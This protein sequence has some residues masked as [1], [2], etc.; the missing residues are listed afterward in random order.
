MFDDVKDME[1]RY[2]LSD[3]WAINCDRGYA[4]LDPII[5]GSLI[6]GK[7]T[8]AEG[9]QHLALSVWLL[10]HKNFMQPSLP[11]TTGPLWLQ[12]CQVPTLQQQSPTQLQMITRQ[13]E[14]VLDVVVHII[15]GP[16]IPS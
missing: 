14:P 4:T 10:D 8:V 9:M 2:R 13:N 5:T 7:L 3:P 15:C 11:I 1:D 16:F 6:L 12:N